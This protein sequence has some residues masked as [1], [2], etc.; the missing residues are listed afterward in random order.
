MMLE[1]PTEIDFY[2]TD[3][4]IIHDNQHVP[5]MHLKDFI[6]E[7]NGI[8]NMKNIIDIF[9]HTIVRNVI[10]EEKYP[11]WYKNRTDFIQASQQSHMEKHDYLKPGSPEFH[12]ICPISFQDSPELELPPIK[13]FSKEV[14][15]V[16]YFNGIQRTIVDGFEEFRELYFSY[17]K[18]RSL[19]MN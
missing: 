13:K 19:N 16:L 1:L 4:I 5:Y 18:K 10:D 3:F 9:K 8:I 14:T 12:S 17:L 7:S 2:K 6:S 15:M 11:E